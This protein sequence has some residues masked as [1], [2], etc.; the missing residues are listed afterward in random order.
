MS[1]TDDR[2]P[3]RQLCLLDVGAGSRTHV[4]PI[5]ID[6][7]DAGLAAVLLKGGGPAG[8]NFGGCRPE[9]V[10]TLV[11]DQDDEGAALIV[12]RVAHLS[13]SDLG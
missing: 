13:C 2:L 9:R 12:E 4:R 6:V 8:R 7:F 5:L 10:F 11:I 1:L 3:T